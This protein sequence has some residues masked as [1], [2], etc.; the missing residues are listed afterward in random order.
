MTR[1]ANV[2]PV[3]SMLVFAGLL[4]TAEGDIKAQQ[5]TAQATPQQPTPEGYVQEDL[6][7]GKDS[8]PA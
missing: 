4:V 6:G 8:R 7:P 5:A 2:A 3:L 1:H